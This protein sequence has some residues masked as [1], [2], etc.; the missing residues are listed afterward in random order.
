MFSEIN[1]YQQE[2]QAIYVQ[3]NKILFWNVP[4]GLVQKKEGYFYFK[5]EYINFILVV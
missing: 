4:F 1:K 2:I 5:N 3:S